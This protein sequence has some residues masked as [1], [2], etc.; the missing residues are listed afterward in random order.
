MAG[1]GDL[2]IYGTLAVPEVM[3]AVTGRSVPLVPATLPGHHCGQVTGAPY[4]GVVPSPGT[5]TR[6]WLME[7]LGPATLRRLDAY[8]GPLYRRSRARV[9][10]PGGR[11]RVAWVY[12]VR[13]GQR[14]R[15]G[16]H[17]W[18]LETFVARD[19]RDYLARRC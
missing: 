11:P 7:G 18:S 16:R 15:V 2:F 9:L 6:G 3:V 1:P 17:P 19:L 5:A 4:P 8:E 10:G 12:V 14:H 13:P